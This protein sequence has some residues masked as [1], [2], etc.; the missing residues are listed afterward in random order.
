MDMPVV[1]LANNKPG[2]LLIAHLC[3]T[4]P[5][6][7]FGKGGNCEAPL[8][9]PMTPP[10]TKS[11]NLEKRRLARPCVVNRKLAMNG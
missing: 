7:R 10:F 1:G 2:A 3:L 5:L 9:L 8:N 4:M 6:C 11:R